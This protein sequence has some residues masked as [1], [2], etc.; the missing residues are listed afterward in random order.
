MRDNNTQ[1]KNIEQNKLFIIVDTEKGKFLIVNM[2]GK[3]YFFNAGYTGG[4]IDI[5]IF[6]KKYA[7]AHEKGTY[8]V[9]EF[10]QNEKRVCDM[11]KNNN[12]KE[13]NTKKTLKK[14]YNLI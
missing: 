13:I 8:S 14:L 4:Y 7:E 9:L 3:Q 10:K 1:K 2:L 5:D 11:L 12:I 6:L